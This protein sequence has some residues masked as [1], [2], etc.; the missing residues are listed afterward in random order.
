M[1]DKQ[2]ED[3]MRD[4][5]KRNH[6]LEPTLKTL[7]VEGLCLALLLIVFAAAGLELIPHG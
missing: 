1:D 7:L 2:F 4:L 6:E 3:F 5:K